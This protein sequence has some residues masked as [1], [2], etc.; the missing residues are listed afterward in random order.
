[1]PAN[2]VRLGGAYFTFTADARG[3]EAGANR[4]IAANRRLAASYGGF[5]RQLQGTQVLAA[6]FG[7]SLRSSLLATT[8]YAAGVGLVSATLRNIVGGFLEYDR[9]LIQISKTTDISGDGLERLGQRIQALGTGPSGL[10][11][12]LP[13]LREELFA[14]ATAAGQAGIGTSRGIEQITRSAAELQVSSNLIGSDAVRALTRYL[15]VTGQAIERTDAIASAYTHLGNNIVG[16][17]AE[18][19]SFA[20]R[21]AQNLSAVGRSTDEFIL[22][23]S[24]T[25]VE[26][27]VQQEAAGSAL[28]RTQIALLRLAGDPTRFHAF[29]DAIGGTA[30]EVEAL[31]QRFVDGTASAEDF[32]RVFLAF[33][34]RV[35]QTR[36]TERQSFIASII[37]GGEANVR[38][39]RVIGVLAERLDRVRRNQNLA[40]EATEEANFHTRE[41]TRAAEAQ[42]SA[43]QIVAN[44]LE[45]QGTAIGRHVNPALIFLAENFRVLELV[46]AG[47][48]A[49]LVAGFGVRRVRGI[50]ETT[51]AIREQAA[52][53]RVAAQAEVAAARQSLDVATRRERGALVAVDTARTETAN[54]TALARANRDTQAA[55]RARQRLAAATQNLN[56]LTARSTSRLRAFG[57]GLLGFVGGPIGLLT[58]ALTLGATAWLLWGNRASEAEERVRSLRDEVQQTVDAI[59][60]QGLTLTGNLVRRLEEEIAR[61][62]DVV[63]NLEIEVNAAPVLLDD[64][65]DFTP[66]IEAL[67]EARRTLGDLEFDLETLRDA[68]G[69]AGDS[70]TDMAFAALQSFQALPASLLSAI[71]AVEAFRNGIEDAARVDVARARAQQLAAT[72]SGNA[73]REALEIEDARAR[74]AAYQISLERQLANIRQQAAEAALRVELLQADRDRLAIGSEAREEAERALTTEQRRLQTLQD[75][76]AALSAQRRLAAGI[77]PPEDLIR[78]TVARERAA[79]VRRTLQEPAQGADLPVSLRRRTGEEEIAIER[80][81]SELRRQAVLDSVAR[82]AASEREEAAIRARA[83]VIDE[84]IGREREAREA[85]EATERTLASV[86]QARQQQ[87]T[88]IRL[89]LVFGRE[90]TEQQEQ[91]FVALR[92]RE[93]AL[94]DERAEQELTVQSLRE[95]AGAYRELANAQAET[96]R[97]SHQGPL[98]DLVDQANRLSDRLEEVA[99]RGF[100][101]LTDSLVTLVTTGKASFRDLANS[102]IADLLRVLIQAQITAPIVQALTG[103]AGG[104]FGGFGAAPGGAAGV[105]LHT[106]GVSQFAPQRLQRPSGLR[107]DELF[108]ILQRGEI[109]LPRS[110]SHRARYGGAQGM[111]ELR[112]WIARLPRFHEGGL[113]GGGGAFRAG[114]GGGAMRIELV[115]QSNTRLEAVDNGTRID[116]ADYVRSVIL[117]DARSNG[118]ITKGLGRALRGS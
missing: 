111:E 16:T 40:A 26:L 99:A 87:E 50:R 89:H 107:G 43:L 55:T 61:Q 88:A 77:T 45:A 113:A 70:A 32:D 100:N 27:D 34:E 68:F 60:A 21:V 81:L 15:Q 112:Q 71:Q 76:V 46:A 44:Q 65:V 31:R 98:D 67:E 117:R 110:L 104:L 22:G 42:S 39:T 94:Q 93:R 80:R 2:N 72:L 7:Q 52:A 28:Q 90:V 1:M 78:E 36:P 97:A 79:E 118:P 95:A 11:P 85:L 41:A 108:A 25:L 4:A 115:N 84:Y 106:G 86:T 53:A 6:Q 57:R 48:A 54:R 8:A 29:S 24:A 62:R 51:A 17:E 38:N 12:A 82:A 14:I 92:D 20:T 35:R 37:G 83:A 13:I 116:G 9:A 58:T 30:D 102:I 96:A 63:R 49:R 3:Y 59:N 109:V 18:I 69:E 114:N 74:I 66:Q 19:A 47:A 75:Q 91:Q 33:L 73:A 23:V 101:S 10:R 105:G 56:V 103:F 5:A 64:A